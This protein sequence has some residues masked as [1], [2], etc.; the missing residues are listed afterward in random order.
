[1]P[2]YWNHANPIDILG[3][4]RAERFQQTVEIC[5]RDPGIDG[6][7]VL[8]SPQAMTDPTETARKLIPLARPGRKPILASWLGGSGVREGRQILDLAGIPTFDSPESAV[9]SF[10]HMVQ[11]R[12][13]QELL[14]ETPE[15][16]T[17]ETV[18]DATSVR[19]ILDD[20]RREERTLLTEPEAKRVLAAYGFLSHP[21]RLAAPLRRPWKRASLRLS[22]RPKLLS[23]VITHKTDVGGVELDFRESQ[24]ATRSSVRETCRTYR[25]KRSTASPFSPW[26]I[27][28]A[29]LIVGVPSIAGPV[30]CWHW[31]IGRSFQ[32]RAR[33]AASEPER[34]LPTHERTHLSRTERN[35]RKKPVDLEALETILVRFSQLVTDFVKSPRSISIRYR[36]AASRLSRLTLASYWLHRARSGRRLRSGPT[37][38]SMLN[39]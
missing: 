1:M 4:A 32:D 33:P 2:P 10:L 39:R 35:S 38:V 21:L 17:G 28:A 36:S 6:I 34:R 26:C 29:E 31:S 8:L 22:C 27:T 20:A 19:A 7:L 25:L 9:Q 18:I 16:P 37:R 23:K 15:A 3:D 14:Y 5:A 11:Y 24:F 13:N 30:C 12:C